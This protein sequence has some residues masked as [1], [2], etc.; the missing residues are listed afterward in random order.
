MLCL[1]WLTILC[2]IRLNPR[3]QTDFPPFWFL[4]EWF[5]WTGE[6]QTQPVKQGRADEN[7][8]LDSFSVSSAAKTLSWVNVESNIIKGAAFTP[9]QEVCV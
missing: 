2:D 1:P 3:S 5:I 9:F 6:D 4:T 7:M 8:G